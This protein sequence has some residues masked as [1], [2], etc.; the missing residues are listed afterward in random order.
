MTPTRDDILEKVNKWMTYGDE[1]LRLAEL[2]VNLSSGCPYR[3][4]AYHAQQCAEKYIKAFL[5]F[6]EIDFPYTHNIS[7]LLELC[8]DQ[9]T[10]VRDIQDAEDL[11]IYAV[12]TRYPDENE[13]ITRQEALDAVVTAT[14]VRETVRTVLIAAGMNI[15]NIEPI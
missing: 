1:D 9:E 14:K 15:S 5:V 11:T 2:A 13:T 4:I 6:K 10:W 8:P 7:V 12:S 3:L